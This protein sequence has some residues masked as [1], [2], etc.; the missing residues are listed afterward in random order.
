[1]AQH[2]EILETEAVEQILD[3]GQGL[4]VVLRSRNR[5]LVCD[6]GP[7]FVSGFEQAPRSLRHIWPALACAASML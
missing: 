7:R 4:G 5:T 3:V 1:M 6:A 2:E